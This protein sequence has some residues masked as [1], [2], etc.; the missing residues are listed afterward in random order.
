[1]S[2]V[3]E[4][5]I[6]EDEGPVLPRRPVKQETDLDMTPMI[7]CTFL[8]LIF[9]TVGATIEPSSAVKLAPAQFG[10]GVDPDACVVITLALRDEAGGAEVYLAAG[11][12][13]SPL[14]GSPEDQ[15]RLIRGYVEDGLSVGKKAV[16]IS[17][18]RGVLHREVTRVATAAAPEDEDI[19]VQFYVAVEESLN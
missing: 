10:V 18:D 11:K 15:S 9:F 14:T 3:V 4:E 13:G 16:L 8:L 2:T 5:P 6:A 17:A 12:M 1:M 7:D 19:S